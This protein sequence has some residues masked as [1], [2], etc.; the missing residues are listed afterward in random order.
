[1]LGKDDHGAEAGDP[2]ECLLGS[3]LN[4]EMGVV[5]SLLANP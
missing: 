5:G 2:G 3:I 4:A 1:M